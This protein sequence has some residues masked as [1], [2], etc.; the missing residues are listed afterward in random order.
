MT[1]KRF[2][3]LL[4][5]FILVCSLAA[6]AQQAP[7]NSCGVPSFSGLANKPNIFSEEQEGWLGDSIDA[8]L[9]KQYNLLQDP[10]GDYLQKFGEH[11]LAQLP[12]TKLHYTFH[13][14]DLPV[15][16]A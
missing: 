15:N 8:T 7:A 9:I 6:A 4:V 1:I 12:P 16:N 14:I 13:L 10:E 2:F 5:F 3:A 11:I